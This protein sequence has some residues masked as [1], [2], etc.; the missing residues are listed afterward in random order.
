MSE[1]LVAGCIETRN[2][3]AGVLSRSYQLL[4]AA[5]VETGAWA[6]IAAMKQMTVHSYGTFGGGYVQLYVSNDPDPDGSGDVGIALGSPIVEAG[7]V[8]INGPYR[9]IRAISAGATGGAINV[10]LHGVA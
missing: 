10:I 7:M 5:N 6:D 2:P 4:K 3:V 1:N 8:S 9:Y